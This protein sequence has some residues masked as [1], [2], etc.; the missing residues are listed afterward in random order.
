MK[1]NSRDGVDVPQGVSS[2]TKGE[3][4]LINPKTGKEYQTGDEIT[5]IRSSGTDEPGWRID[6]I[7]NEGRFRV[8][9]P[10]GKMSTLAGNGQIGD[11]TPGTG[12]NAQFHEVRAI[13]VDSKGN[14][15]VAQNGGRG[16]CIA[17]ISPAGVVTNFA[18]DIN[19]LLPTGVNH[20]GTGKAARFMRI[21]A[22]LIDKDDNLLIGENTRVRRAS[23][24]GLVTTLAGNENSDWRDAAGAKAM[25]RKIAGI[26][27]DS[28]GNILISDQYCIRK[29]T[30]Q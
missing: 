24:A 29:M 1:I 23:P 12:R 11:F 6:S 2:E 7:N 10:D 30:K 28:K 4:K 26:S 21:N 14:V 5:V 13:A 18:G 20:D 17:I 22:L 9:S 27:I 15:F 3:K 8:I 19:A 16:S 25:F